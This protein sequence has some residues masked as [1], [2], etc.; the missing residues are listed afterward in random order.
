M[1]RFLAVFV[2]ILFVVVMI[3]AIAAYFYKRR[4][5]MK[6]MEEKDRFGY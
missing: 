2:Q 4:Q 6:R 1:I 3:A 5:K